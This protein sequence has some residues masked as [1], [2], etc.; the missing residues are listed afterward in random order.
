[1]NPLPWRRGAGLFAGGAGVPACHDA[2]PF[3]RLRHRFQIKEGGASKNTLARHD[4][5]DACLTGNSERGEEIR[6]WV[7]A[8]GLAAGGCSGLIGIRDWKRTAIDRKAAQMTVRSELLTATDETIDDAVRHA[9]PMVLRGLLYQLTG[10]ES[11]A[12]TESATITVRNV[13]LNGVRPSGS[14]AA[15]ALRPEPIFRTPNSICGWSNWRWTR[16]CAN[17]IGRRSHPSRT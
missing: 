1:V 2:Q 10:D 3:F 6:H 14:S 5:K 13:E 16:G 15:S 17:S 7:Q 4:S 8:E 11:I 9:D 12:A